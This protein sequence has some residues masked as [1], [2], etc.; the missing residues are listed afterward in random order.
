MAKSLER[1]INILE[2]YATSS[3]GLED[4]EEYQKE[5]TE[6][7]KAIDILYAASR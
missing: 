5:C 1:A 3:S 2:I 4:D 7:W 6:I